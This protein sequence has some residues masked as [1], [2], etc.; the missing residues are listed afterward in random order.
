MSMSLRTR[1]LIGYLVF[2]T[3]LAALG[4]WSA[5]RLDEVGAVARR[6]LS[7]NYESVVAALNM[8]ESLER[9]DSAALFALIGHTDLA[10][11]QLQEHRRRFDAAFERAANNLTEPGESQLIA[12]IRHDR[13]EYYRSFDQFLAALPS[14]TGDRGPDAY[15]STME[16]RFN[17]LR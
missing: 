8:K 9:Q 2:V 6:I 15:F 10:V 16:P 3:A 1:L 12:A 17:E 11:R 5:W 7:E 14:G 4:G 13:D